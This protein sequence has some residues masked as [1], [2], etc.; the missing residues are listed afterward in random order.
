MVQLISNSFLKK[1][2]IYL[3]DHEHLR[4]GARKPIL[5]KGPNLELT[6]YHSGRSSQTTQDARLPA[7][8]NS[9][10]YTHCSWQDLGCLLKRCRCHVPAI[11]VASANDDDDDDDDDED[12]DNMI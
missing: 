8:M 10:S 5:I 9:E 4:L 7:C 2:D 6:F 3:L 12:D 11:H 1:G